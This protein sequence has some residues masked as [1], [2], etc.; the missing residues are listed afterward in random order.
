MIQFLRPHGQSPS[1]LDP[2]EG[3]REVWSEAACGVEVKVKEEDW[4]RDS[5]RGC[6]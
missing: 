5:V 4:R 2:E 6:L 3:L 1:R